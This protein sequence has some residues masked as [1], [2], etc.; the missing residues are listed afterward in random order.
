MHLDQK[1]VNQYKGN[2]DQFKEMEAQKRKQQVRFLFS[3]YYFLFPFVNA[4]DGDIV[5][6]FCPDLFRH[7]CFAG[8]V[9]AKE[10]EKQ[11]RKLASLKKGGQSKGKAEDTVRECIHAMGL[12]C[13]TQFGVVCATLWEGVCTSCVD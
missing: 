10:W 9:Q 8:G 4:F 13:A 1:R 2:Y 3:F 11:Q 7:C 12:D 5:V 6:F